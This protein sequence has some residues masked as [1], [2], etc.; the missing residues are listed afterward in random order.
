MPKGDAIELEGVV[1]E[2]SNGKFKVQVNEKLIVLC[3]LSGKIRINSVRIIVG[4]RVAIEVS[5]YEITKGRIT[6]RMKATG[7]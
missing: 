4:D 6:Y 7:K 5:P 3:T 2:C 1:I